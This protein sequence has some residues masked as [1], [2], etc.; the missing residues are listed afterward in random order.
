M[1]RDRHRGGG[2]DWEHGDGKIWLAAEHGGTRG[3]EGLSLALSWSAAIPG[4]P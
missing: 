1:S 4:R 3:I 2:P